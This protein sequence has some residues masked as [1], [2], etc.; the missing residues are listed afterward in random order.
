MNI[1]TIL[2]LNS[3]VLFVAVVAL[4][5]LMALLIRSEKKLAKHGESWFFK[6]KNK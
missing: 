5:V 4:S 2:V 3:V 6:R 1:T